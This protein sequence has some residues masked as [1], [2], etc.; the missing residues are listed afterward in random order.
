MKLYN[1]PFDI[2]V[3]RHEIFSAG[4]CFIGNTPMKILGIKMGTVIVRHLYFWD[5]MMIFVRSHTINSK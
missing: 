1:K 5:R 4:N 3:A 2:R